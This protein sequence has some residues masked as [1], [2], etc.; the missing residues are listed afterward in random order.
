MRNSDPDSDTNAYSASDADTNTKPKRAASAN[1][2]A[3][4]NASRDTTASTLE[5]RPPQSVCRHSRKF[6]SACGYA[7]WIDL[8]STLRH[9]PS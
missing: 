1:S 7:G 2:R 5:V 4:R 8:S 9:P 6:A 3:Q